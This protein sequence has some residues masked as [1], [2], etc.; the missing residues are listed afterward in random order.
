MCVVKNNKDI[1]LKVVTFNE[2]V[3]FPFLVIKRI[4]LRIRKE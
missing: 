3:F 4:K 1:K 2:I